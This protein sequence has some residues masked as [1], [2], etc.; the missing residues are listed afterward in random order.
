MI[1]EFNPKKTGIKTMKIRV[2]KEYP[3][4]KRIPFFQGGLK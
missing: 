1:D 4:S 2:M 3:D